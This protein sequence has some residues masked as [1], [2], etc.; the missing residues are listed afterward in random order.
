MI[1][2]RPRRRR[3]VVP[4][5]ALILLGVLAV[6][7]VVADGVA[8]DRVE[9][10]VATRVQQELGSDVPPL[11]DSTGRPTLTQLLAGDLTHLDV[12]TG[13]VRV[14][15]PQGE[16]ALDRLELS[17]DH[18]R[19]S[20][21][22]VTGS[23]ERVSGVTAVGFAEIS[24]LAGREVRAGEQTPDG[25]RWTT[26]ADARVLGLDVPLEVS[27]LPVLD[28]PSGRQLTLSQV[29]IAVAGYDVPPA[30]ADRIIEA[31]V[32][33]IPFELPFGLAAD[34]LASTPEGLTLE[35]SGTDV[36]VP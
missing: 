14:A 33:P 20:D 10:E 36:T 13:P 9:T 28:G 30:V 21:R 27:G 19:S 15:G 26:T 12:R 35:F 22:F 24:R 18:L 7:V 4:L 5:V 23:A 8:E 6:G 2:L 3:W 32:R 17:V 11:V 29:E 16:L 1:R 25:T 34:T 31:A